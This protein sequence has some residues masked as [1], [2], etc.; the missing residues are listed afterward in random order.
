MSAVK[1]ILICYHD[2][3]RF[4]VFQEN[5]MPVQAIAPNQSLLGWMLSSLGWADLLALTAG[6]LIFAG[7]CRLVMRKS[8]PA[9]LAAYLVLLPLPVL[10]SISG[11]LKGMISS[12]TV[13]AATPDL[14]VTTADF[15]GGIAVSLLSLFVAMMISAPSYLLLAT[16]L[17]FR[18]ERETVAPAA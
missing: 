18:A 10:I 2:G 14:H 16:G 6:L 13:I 3:S 15:A 4:P 5:I 17:L 11:T 8:Q 12:F 9:A 7:A 1:A